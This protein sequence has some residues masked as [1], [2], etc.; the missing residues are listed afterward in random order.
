MNTPSRRMAAVLAVAVLQ[1]AINAHGAESNPV[2][3]EARTPPGSASLDVLIKLRPEVSGGSAR[4]LS[5][6]QSSRSVELARRTGVAIQL[7]REVSD[8]L[9]ATHIDLV[10]GDPDRALA[11]LRADSRG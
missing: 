4:K 1:A 11:A 10:D 5:A 2:A 7:R 3:H 8:R 6:Q 9:V